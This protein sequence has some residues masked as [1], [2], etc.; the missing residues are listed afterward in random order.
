MIKLTKLDGKVFYL[1][2]NLVETIEPTPDTVITLA[3]GRKLL[4]QE[5]AET[6]VEKILVFRR[7]SNIKLLEN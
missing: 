1:N 7:T 2:P 6:V 4:V 5:S 3:G